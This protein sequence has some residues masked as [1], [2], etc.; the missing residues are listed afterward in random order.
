MTPL[1]EGGRELCSKDC[2]LN[3][4]CLINR[5]KLKSC[6]VVDYNVDI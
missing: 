6:L 3:E 5:L 2:R 4:L 1:W